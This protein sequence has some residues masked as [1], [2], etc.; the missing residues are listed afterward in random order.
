MH[1]ALRVSKPTILID[2]GANIGLSSLSLIEEFNSLKKVIAIEAEEENFGVLQSNFRLWSKRF[3]NLLLEPMHAVATSD[4]DAKM[5]EQ[6]SLAELTG[7][8]SAS[9]TFRFEADST[10]KPLN[11][12]V[13]SSISI[14]DLFDSF[15]PNESIIVKIDIEGGEEYLMRQN[16]D[17]V[18]AAS[19]ITMEIHDHFH[20]VMLNSS[21][22]MIKILA[23]A[24]FAIKP[25]DDVLHCYNRDKLFN[26][27]TLSE[28]K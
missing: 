12:R 2:I 11:S 20:P 1:D 4:G 5:T 21:K 19:F 13:L 3:P 24:N 8:N 18:R 28:L 25:S 6:T 7:N 15:G 27:K 22:N 16:T 10:D 17:W 9:G 26:E 14:Q 23:D